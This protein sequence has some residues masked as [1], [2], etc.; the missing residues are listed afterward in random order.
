MKWTLALTLFATL[1]ACGGGD[2][3]DDGSTTADASAGTADGMPSGADANTPTADAMPQGE[4]S[5]TS[6]ALE[7]GQEIPTIHTCAGA[8]ISPPFTWSGGPDVAGY[9]MVFR[10]VQQG[11]EL[12]HSIIYDIPGS[13]TSLPE[14]VEKVAEPSV[15]AGA[16]Q[17]RA[18]LSDRRGYLGPCPQKQHDYEFRLY[19]IDTYPLPGVTTQSS[20]SAVETAILANSSAVDVLRIT[21]T[22]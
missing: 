19:A 21:H 9:A 12:I 15:P 3:D 5:L 6:T 1:S 11:R 4:F 18:Y 17:T 22:P 13:V 14:N 2:D 8:N 10:D 20:R 7:E 16:K